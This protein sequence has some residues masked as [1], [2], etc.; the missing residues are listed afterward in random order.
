MQ[1][2]AM[3]AVNLKPGKVAVSLI[4]RNSFLNLD[5]YQACWTVTDSAGAVIQSGD[6]SP[7]QLRAGKANQSENSRGKIAEAGGRPGILAAGQFPYPHRV[8]CGRR[9]DLKSRGS[10]SS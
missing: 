6:L 3:A 2:I 9:R 5:Q 8:P 4:N 1:P 7:H 10:N